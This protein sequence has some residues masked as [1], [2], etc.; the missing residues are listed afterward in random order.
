MAG[1]VVLI[2]SMISSATLRALRPVQF[3]GHPLMDREIPVMDAAATLQRFAMTT[4]RPI[5]GL[6]PGS[7]TSEIQRL[8]PVML[9]AASRI[10]MEFPQAQFIIPVAPG[11]R[12]EEIKEHVN[13]HGVP[14]TIITNHLHQALHICD[15]V[16][17]ASG[18]ATLET[19]LM[20]KPM[21][22][23]YRVSLLTYLIGRLMV[24]VSTIGLANIVA[25]KQIVPELI[26][27][28]ASPQR[29]SREAVSLLKDPLRMEAMAEELGRVREL[30]GGAGASERVARIAYEM[31]KKPKKP[32]VRSQ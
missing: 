17:V 15:L 31:L 6:L 19:A 5:M 16:L 10:Q 23:M 4:Q 7:R 12:P 8:L 27:G 11:I 2:C 1:W 18:T 26:Q 9:A 22:I 13:R 14:V 28:D 20:K 24:R 21:I 3:V 32:G 25:G 29:V 30:L